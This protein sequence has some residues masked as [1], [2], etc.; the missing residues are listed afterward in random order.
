M[1]WPRSAASTFRIPALGGTAGVGQLGGRLPGR[2]L[3]SVTLPR[4]LFTLCR[5]LGSAP[6]SIGKA[7]GLSDR[8]VLLIRHTNPS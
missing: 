2:L 1:F 5:W 3:A 6:G 4:A 7:S 8:P